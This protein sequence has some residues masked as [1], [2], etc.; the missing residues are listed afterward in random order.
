MY[1]FYLL[2]FIPVS[3]SCFIQ[4][5][6][7]SQFQQWKNTKVKEQEKKKKKATDVLLATRTHT[8]TNKRG[9]R[10]LDAFLYFVIFSPPFFM[11][12]IMNQKLTLPFNSLLHHLHGLATFEQDN[13]VW[14]GVIW[15]EEARFIIVDN[16]KW[17]RSTRGWK[18]LWRSRHMMEQAYPEI[19]QG[20]SLERENRMKWAPIIFNLRFP[21]VC[22][23]KGPRG[24]RNMRSDL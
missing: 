23:R 12:F 19:G 5:R 3:H 14:K 2:Q 16:G 1:K 15:S 10:I 22:V 4:A 7:L 9:V 8:H 24:Q 13:V 21:W 6:P 11:F 17:I 18:V 20:D